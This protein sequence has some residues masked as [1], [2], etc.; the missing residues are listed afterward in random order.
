[1]QE[2]HREM[3]ESLIGVLGQVLQQAK[4]AELSD[5]LGSKVSHIFDRHGGVETLN[6]QITR[7]TAFHD[8][9]YLPLL[10]PFHANNRAVIFR[11]LDQIKIESA[12]QDTRLLNAVEFIREHRKSRRELLPCEINLRFMSTRWRSF[13]QVK[14]DNGIKLPPGG[15]PVVGK[16]AIYAR[17]VAGAEEDAA[18]DIDMKIMNEEFEVAG[19]WAF[20]RG[21]YT[22]EVTPKAGG[23]TVFKEGKY[24]TILQKQPDGTWKLYRDIYNA[25]PL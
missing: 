2:K 1:M 10:W 13:I 15:M 16:E 3:E 19:D 6:D 23:D 9:N 24:L 14:D 17:H 11:V 4:A 5:E 8:N 12:T 25:N 18:F 20:C 22:Y 21:T 7:V